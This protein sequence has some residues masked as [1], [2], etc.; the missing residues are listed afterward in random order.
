MT[1][2]S[3]L[4]PK[5]LSLETLA[6]RLCLFWWNRE[7]YWNL[8][9]PYWNPWLWC[10]KSCF[11]TFICIF[12]CL[13]FC[14]GFF[15][16]VLFQLPLGFLWTQRL[17]FF[18]HDFWLCSADWNDF[19]DHVKNILWEETFNLGVLGVDVGWNWCLY[20]S[21]LILLRGWS[22]A[23]C[24]ADVAHINYFFHLYQENIL[25]KLPNLLMLIKQE[26]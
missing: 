13:P 19:R 16:H 23:T 22:S 9:R 2:Q 15:D 20:S 5:Y 21:S 17:L 10:I 7:T 12:W 24:A 3:T 26:N 4:Q 11:L 6:S 1:S 18:C 25:A 8:K 14:N